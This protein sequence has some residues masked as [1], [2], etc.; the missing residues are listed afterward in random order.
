MSCN[1][2][3]PRQAFRKSSFSGGEGGSCLEIAFASTDDTV[4]ARDSKIVFGAQGDRHL[5]MSASAFANFRTAA[6][7]GLV[8]A[9]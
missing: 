6:R 5:A 8:A 2:D 9:S 4:V 7:N 1:T 3:L